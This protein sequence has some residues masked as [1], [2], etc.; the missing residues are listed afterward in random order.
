MVF[1]EWT[2]WPACPLADKKSQGAFQAVTI[3]IVLLTVWVSDENL[4]TSIG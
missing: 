1:A 4:A 3:G 2:D